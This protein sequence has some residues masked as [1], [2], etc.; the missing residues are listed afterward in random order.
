[1]DRLLVASILTRQLQKLS[2]ESLSKYVEVWL[3]ASE[4]SVRLRLSDAESLFVDL[5]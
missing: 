5:A 2:S 1:M 4:C 3:T